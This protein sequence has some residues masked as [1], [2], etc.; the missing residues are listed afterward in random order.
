MPGD[1]LEIPV[2][3]LGWL[4]TYLGKVRFDGESLEIVVKH[5]GWWMK[6][7]AVR[8]PL[9]EIV[10]VEVRDGVFGFALRI[11]TKSELALGD[12]PGRVGEVVDLGVEKEHGERAVPFAQAVAHAQADAAIRDAE[13]GID[14]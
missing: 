5:S 14:A 3:A 4:W 9:V 7:Y 10:S 1:V 12:V 11:R 2:Y 8:I 6:E 13:A